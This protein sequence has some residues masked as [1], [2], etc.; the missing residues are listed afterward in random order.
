MVDAS[1]TMKL[2]TLEVHRLGFGTMQLTGPG[3]FGP[4]ADHDGAVGVPC[5]D[6]EA[7]QIPSERDA[8]GRR[9]ARRCARPSGREWS[10]SAW[11]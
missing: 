9:G 5:F 4:P 7:R 11:R 2:G 8:S 3:V 6:E 10:S 1:D